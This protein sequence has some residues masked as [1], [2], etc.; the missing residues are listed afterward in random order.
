KKPIFNT[1][2]LYNIYTLLML[3][4][5]LHSNATSAQERSVDFENFTHKRYAMAKMGTDTAEIYFKRASS[6][7]KE[8]ND[9]VNILLCAAHLANI[10][11]RRGRY[12]Q[13]FEI[14]TSSMPMAEDISDR[15]AIIELNQS[16]AALYKVY[17]KDSLTMNLTLRN[18]EIAKSYAAEQGISEEIRDLRTQK[19]KS[20]YLSVAVQALSTNDL[21]LAK[22]YIDSC[23]LVKIQNDNNSF[24]N[25]FLAQYYIKKG[26]YKRA[27]TNLDGT[28]EYM[29]ANRNGFLASIYRFYGEIYEAKNRPDSAQYYY[30]K[31]IDAIDSY[32]VSLAGKPEILERLAKLHSRKG[33]YKTAYQQMQ[34]AKT[35][36]DSLFTLQSQQNKKL[37]DIKNDYRE[38]IAHERATI[39][40]QEETLKASH[41]F[42]AVL[43]GLIIFITLAFIGVIISVRLRYKLRAIEA[44]KLLNEEKNQ[45]LLEKKNRELTANALQSVEKEQIISEFIEIVGDESPQLKDQLKVKLN[46]NSDQMWEEFNARFTETNGRFYDDL[47]KRHPP[48]TASDLKLCALLRLNFD[49]KEMS[50]LLGISIGSIHV[51]RSRL[52]KRLGLER[53]DN[54]NNYLNSIN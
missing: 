14:V 40:Q 2:K 51:S 52:R 44:E 3:L 47:I 15:L 35:L 7:F 18:L 36:T 45:A 6:H 23:Y 27:L 8:K 54:L 17:G 53:S 42:R 24:I 41:R 30:N 34:S 21:N 50:R 25:A 12:N 49:S 19:C 31:V 22:S 46:Q 4:L 37:F 11:Y 16:L 48:L 5:T 26:D 39:A 38:Q 20:G 29:T 9:T 10:E 28:V 13:A 43:I 32:E 33:N 1:M